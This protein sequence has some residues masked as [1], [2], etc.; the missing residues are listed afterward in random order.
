MKKIK[1]SINRFALRLALFSL[2]LGILQVI[3]YAIY[4]NNTSIS[5]GMMHLFPTVAIHTIVLIIVIINSIMNY[6]DIAEHFLVIL[7][8]LANIPTAFTCFYV[9]MT[10]MDS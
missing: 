3:I 10:I 8:M 7:G 1:H 4:P 6:K 5:I 2:C 9:V